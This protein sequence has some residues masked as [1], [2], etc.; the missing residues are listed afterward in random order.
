VRQSERTPLYDAALAQLA[1]RG[2]IYECACT[3]RELEGMPAHGGERVYPGTCRNGVPRSLA[4]RRQRSLRVK[5]RDQSVSFVDRLQGVQQQDLARDVGDFVLKRADGWFAY[6]LAVVVDD[7]HQA[8][9]SVVRGAD[10]LA[11]T[12]RQIFL[13][14][15]LGLATPAYLH[16]PI[17]VDRNGQK[18]SK[19][20]DAPALTGDP[21]AALLAAWS[22]L[23][24]APP[25][26]TPR[27]TAEFWAHGARAWRVQQL[28][29]VSAKPARAY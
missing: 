29:R 25:L 2:L 17:A 1:A 21:V 4:H 11:S 27:T 24:Q 19:Q 9:T 14:R 16:V 3:R 13:Q 26:A 5:V 22:F 28:P 10:L 23:E 18:L 12:P 20:T 6:Q 8:I 15:A 7:A